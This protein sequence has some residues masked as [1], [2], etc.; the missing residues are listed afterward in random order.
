VD[1]LTKSDSRVDL[2]TWASVA[3]TPGLPDLETLACHKSTVALT[4]NRVA[5][6]ANNMNVTFILL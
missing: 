5:I 1:L 6:P 3:Q 4:R 2:L